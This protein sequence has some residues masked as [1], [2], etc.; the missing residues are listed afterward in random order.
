MRMIMTFITQW[1]L[2]G[3]SMNELG[4]AIDKWVAGCS[5]TCDWERWEQFYE[6]GAGSQI[7]SMNNFDM[8]RGECQSY[9]D[10]QGAVCAFFRWYLN[11][12]NKCRCYD[13]TDFD[14]SLYDNF[15]ASK[16]T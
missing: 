10:D 14:A 8:T 16:C 3:V 1:R 5:R 4:D 6:C 2:G 13:S 12:D 15:W 7:G 9:C 11:G